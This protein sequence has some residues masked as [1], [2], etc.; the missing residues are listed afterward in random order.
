MAR[1]NDRL[2]LK[3]S[4]VE[5]PSRRGPKGQ[6]AFIPGLE[7]GRRNPMSVVILK[8]SDILARPWAVCIRCRGQHQQD[9]VRSS[10]RI[11]L[12]G[13]I[14]SILRYGAPH[15]SKTIRSRRGFLPAISLV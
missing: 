2:W 4:P 11:S 6:A 15:G 1:S 9:L 5:L 3:G 12:Q 10:K 13:K 8:H 7:I 14:L